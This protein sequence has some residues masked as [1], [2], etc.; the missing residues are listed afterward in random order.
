MNF[1]EETVDI[2][3]CLARERSEGDEIDPHWKSVLPEV[4]KI[5]E[6]EIFLTLHRWYINEPMKMD[7]AQHAQQARPRDLK[8]LNDATLH[9]HCWMRESWLGI[10]D[11]RA[12]QSFVDS[13]LKGFI[14]PPDPVH[15]VKPSG[16][17]LPIS[18]GTARQIYFSLV[19]R[20][21]QYRF[22]QHCWDE[23]MRRIR[24]SEARMH[25]TLLL[26]CSEEFPTEQ[27]KSYEWLHDKAKKIDVDVD[28]RE[29]SI[30]DCLRKMLEMPAHIQV[31]RSGAILKAIRDRAIDIYRK[32]GQYESI[33]LDD[34]LADAMPDK[35]AQDL[36]ERM[37]ADEI[38]Q[39]LLECQPQIEEIL[40]QGRPEKRKQGERRFKV[41]QLLAHTP[42]LTSSVIANQLRT[43][44]PT[45]CRDRK[46]IER[47]R[48]RIKAV[49]QD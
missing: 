35:S 41:I 16:I 45:I 34:E 22:A 6:N 23:L 38:P 5:A 31:Q 20:Y 2:I 10:S 24:T 9:L 17:L 42:N 48:D 40:S 19:E 13:N 7:A 30:H 12:F 36:S 43:S 3:N 21:K 25:M 29:D 39:R 37:L 18:A 33:P 44:E 14:H 28:V 4:S 47:S 26:T 8:D 46:V 32:G 49:L 11:D 1:V 15:W 27:K